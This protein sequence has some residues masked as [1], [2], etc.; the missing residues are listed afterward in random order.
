MKELPSFTHKVCANYM[1]PCDSM[2]TLTKEV[3]VCVCTHTY[4]PHAVHRPTLQHWTP[5][6]AAQ[7]NSMPDNRA[8]CS[9][10]HDGE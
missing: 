9:H 2:H 5:N 8:V 3:R 7:D 6:K 10:T 1:Y 4:M